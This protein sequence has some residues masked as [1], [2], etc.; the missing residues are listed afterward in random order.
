M[1]GD[2]HDVSGSGST[3][4]TRDTPYFANPE[5][6]YSDPDCL[7]QSGVIGDMTITFGPY[8]CTDDATTGGASYERRGNSGYTLR[9]SGTCDDTRTAGNDLITTNVTFA[10]AQLLCP[11]EDCSADPNATSEMSGVY[12]QTH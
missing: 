10:G 9:F 3:T 11:P 4:F 7:S 1:T 5:G 8:A 12:T 6:T 2:F